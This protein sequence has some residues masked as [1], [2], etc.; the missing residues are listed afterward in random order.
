MCFQ[1]KE[2]SPSVTIWHVSCIRRTALN[3]TRPLP[4]GH[5]PFSVGAWRVALARA[6]TAALHALARRWQ[7]MQCGLLQ[8]TEVA[9]VTDVTS[10]R[11]G[12][13]EF[14][15]RLE[16]CRA[17]LHALASTN[18]QRHDKHRRVLG[19][20]NPYD[21]FAGPAGHSTAPRPKPRGLHEGT[22]PR[23]ANTLFSCCI[24]AHHGAW[25]GHQT[26]HPVGWI[27]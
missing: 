8:K 15:G 6:R 1:R 12:M 13:H 2:L 17:G 18:V 7:S 23:C 22:K 26:S 24:D 11:D 20:S 27:K 4:S 10:M 14:M 16:E 3:G 5:T 19:F 21:H 25:H 9:K